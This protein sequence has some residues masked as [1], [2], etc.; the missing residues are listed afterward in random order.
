LVAFVYHGFTWASGHHFT[1]LH[2]AGNRAELAEFAA[3]TTIWTF[4]PSVAAAVIMALAA[5]WLLV[6]FGKDFASG[7]MVTIILL[8]GLLAR[9]AIGPA[10]QLLIM[11]DNQMACVKAYGLAFVINLL[12]CIA[13]VP[14]YGG[15]GAAA[16]TAAAYVL[17]SVI[18]AIE[19]RRRLGF[20]VTIVHAL[21]PQR[22][23]AHA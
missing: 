3:R 23:A 7:G 4:L 22:R 11:T 13:L 1:A 14:H 21:L 17:A 2:Q 20:H 6:L 15:I 9:A 19:V 18:V 5:P 10:E 12:F 16:S 8:A